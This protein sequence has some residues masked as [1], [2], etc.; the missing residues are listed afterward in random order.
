MKQENERVPHVGMCE[1]EGEWGLGPSAG[2]VWEGRWGGSPPSPPQT[3]PAALATKP[4]TSTGRN[5]PKA[6]EKTVPA[7]TTAF[8]LLLNSSQGLWDPM[9]IRGGSRKEQLRAPKAV[10]T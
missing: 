3:T 7:R 9:S 6:P 10:F 1:S 8:S 4:A 5:L 2:G